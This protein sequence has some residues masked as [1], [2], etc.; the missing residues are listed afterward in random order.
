MREAI[1]YTIIYRFLVSGGVMGKKQTIK[2]KDT[3]KS[4]Q[5]V[6]TQEIYRYTE[7]RFN[8]LLKM[9]PKDIKSV[10][11][12]GSGNDFFRILAKD[13]I[14]MDLHGADINQDLNINPKIALPSKSRDLVIV[15]NIL[16]HLADPRIVVEESK[17]ISRKYVLIG[18]PNE[19]PLHKR[20]KLL[21]GLC[22]QDMGIDIYGHKHKFSIKSIDKF[23]RQN[24]GTVIFKKNYFEFPG[25]RFT[26]AFV[27]DFLA[28]A[29]PNLFAGEV[30]YLADIRDSG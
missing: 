13:Y 16:E 30:F 10:L 22:E 26:P 28:D 9:L 23:V 8:P 14:G 21:F 7:Y 20:L 29:F 4:S 3:A 24:Y 18:L 2:S 6:K 12:I 19:F 17:R 27:R 11:D 1:S 5:D 25:G 15:S